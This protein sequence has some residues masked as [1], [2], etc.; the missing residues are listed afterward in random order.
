MSP[1]TR[2]LRILCLHGF[3]QNPTLF[4]AKTAALR[5]ALTKHFSPA[6]GYDIHFFYLP[7]PHR[8]IPADIPGCV[9]DVS[10]TGDEQPET[11]GWWIGKGS[12]GGMGSEAK[13]EH[14]YEGVEQSMDVI[15]DCI[16]DEGPFDGVIG[17]SQGAAAAAMTASMLEGPERVNAF[18]EKSLRFGGIPFPKALLTSERKL[19]QPPIK[20]AVSYCGFIARDIR[21]CA[22]FYEPEIKTPVLHVIGEV[23]VIVERARSQALVGVCKGGPDRVVTHPGGHFVP[24]QKPMLDT[25]VG[26]IRSIVEEDDGKK[27]EAEESV[28]DMDVPF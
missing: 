26:F 24:C 12:E 5:K 1:N 22:A 2:P 6:R 25:V 15:A 20:F 14:I 19:M 8:I 7:G 11:L 23:D 9:P 17:F 28:E 13:G 10:G 27:P 16:R 21:R 4:S 18:D 3:T